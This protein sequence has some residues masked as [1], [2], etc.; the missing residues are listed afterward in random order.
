[1]IAVN[2]NKITT[3]MKTPND[4]PWWK[5]VLGAIVALGCTIIIS[6]IIHYAYGLINGWLGLVGVVTFVCVP[7]WYFLTMLEW[8]MNGGNAGYLYPWWTT[9]FYSVYSGIRCFSYE[10]C[11]E[12]AGVYLRDSSDVAWHDSSTNHAMMLY[13]SRWAFMVTPTVFLVLPITISIIVVY[14]RG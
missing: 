14:F 10:Y 8:E 2:V 4:V 13:E 3:I 11:K 6:V 5:K 12:Y 9:P 1:M 7:I